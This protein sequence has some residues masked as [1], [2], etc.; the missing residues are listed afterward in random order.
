MDHHDHDGLVQHVA[1]I[2]QRMM[3]RCRALAIARMTPAFTGS[4]S[5]GDVASALIGPSA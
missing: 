4:L 3:A 2:G 1:L 5:A